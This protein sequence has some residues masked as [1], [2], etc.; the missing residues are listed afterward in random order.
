VL[1]IATTGASK[2]VFGRSTGGIGVYGEATATSG[3][4]TGVRGYT[5]ST[6]GTGVHGVAAATSGGTNGILGTSASPAGRGVQ[7]TNTAPGGTGV[8]GVA[9]S[10]SNAKGVHGR[11]TEGSGVYG[12]GWV[13][14]RGQ[15]GQ[16]YGVFAEG[17]S[18]GIRGEAFLAGGVGVYGIAPDGVAI[19]FGTRGSAGSPA[20]RGVQGDNTGMNGTGVYGIAPYGAGARGVIARAD[21]GVGLEAQGGTH[22]VFAT[23]ATGVEGVS[24]GGNGVYGHTTA[25]GTSGVYGESFPPPE[26][27]NISYGVAGRAVLYGL[28]GQATHP[29][30]AQ[31]NGGCGVVGNA[32]AT[33]GIGVLGV[34]N[35]AG[36]I[37]VYGR[38]AAGAPLAGYFQG[39]VTVTGTFTA[40]SS[41]MLMDHPDAPAQRWYR[42][43]PVGSFE[44]VSVISGNTVTNASGRAG[45][46]VPALFA[47]HHSDVRYQLTLVGQRGT[48]WVLNDLDARGRFTIATDI[49]N[50]R[51]SWQLTGVRTD[52]AAKGRPLRVDAAKPRRQRGRYLQPDLY[53]QPRTEALISTELR[54][55]GPKPPKRPRRSG[56]SRARNA[57]SQSRTRPNR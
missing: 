31:G 25:F 3:P 42:Q 39:D 9:N 30:S 6:S 50:A 41:F 53:G 20:G 24:T 14:V 36:S 19:N 40:P 49:P 51:V 7:G 47:R 57:G 8:H 43:A 46:R 54:G 52:P 35:G 56:A 21:E 10:G 15:S 23:G 29:G 16:G 38:S 2:G 55:K 28:W 45:V 26:A 11:S 17:G 32:G 34:C 5:P 13:G 12:E 33:N 22:G 18:H 4:A 37:A 44:Q 1:G 48:S 27:G